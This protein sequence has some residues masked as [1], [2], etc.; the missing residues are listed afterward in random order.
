MRLWHKL[1]LA[2]IPVLILFGWVYRI[3]ELR[4]ERGAELV[5]DLRTQETITPDGSLNVTQGEWH[6]DDPSRLPPPVVSTILPTPTAIPTYER[7]DPVMYMARLSF[8]WPD[9]GAP[10][11]CHPANWNDETNQC[12]TTLFDG[13]IREHWTNWINTGVACPI[14]LPLGT[15]IIIH[16]K[17]YPNVYVC[18]DRGSAI[19][20]LPDG[21]IRIDLLQPDPIWVQDGDVIRD[22]YSPSGSFLVAIEVIE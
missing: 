8:Y 9:L 17:E 16:A 1:L 7:P 19:T 14:E 20:A 2:Q 4:I 5:D 10:M 3:Q 21:S 6:Q 11:N 15:K 13:R 12:E 18:V 22:E